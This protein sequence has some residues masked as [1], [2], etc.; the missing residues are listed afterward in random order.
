[1]ILLRQSCLVKSSWDVWERGALV[2]AVHVKKSCSNV[3]LLKVDEYWG[4]IPPSRH[5]FVNAEYFLF[6]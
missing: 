3:D 6:L 4:Q 1:M 2:S 5:A